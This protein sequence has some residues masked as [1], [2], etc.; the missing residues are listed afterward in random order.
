M[1]GSDH[2]VELSDAI[3]ALRAELAD[4]IERGGASAIRFQ[5]QPV[6]LT[7]QAVVTKDVNGRIGWGALGVGAKYEAAI[8][9]TLKLTLKPVQ[10]TDTGLVD[11]TV[12]DA[13]GAVGRLGPKA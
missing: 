13:G 8:T 7:L 2:I 4:A 11:L 10:Q 5:V 12:A 3:E 6:E 9:Q 1:S